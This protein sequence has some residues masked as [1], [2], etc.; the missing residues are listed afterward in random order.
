MVAVGSAMQKREVIVVGINDEAKH[1]AHVHREPSG[2]AVKVEYTADGAE[3]GA[4][5]DEKVDT[6][7]A[8]VP[9]RDNIEADVLNRDLPE[10]LA[11]VVQ[12]RA[13][14]DTPEEGEEQ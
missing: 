4:P 7:G 11:H 10:S 3:N 1:A 5:N 6:L 13:K 14:W 12:P 2:H 9:D 8:M